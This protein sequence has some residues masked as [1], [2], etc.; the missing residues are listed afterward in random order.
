MLKQVKNN[1]PHEK[2]STNMYD[3]YTW[4]EKVINSCT[5]TEQ[6]SVSRKLVSAFNELYSNEIQL[7]SALYQQTHRLW[8]DLLDKEILAKVKSTHTKSNHTQVHNG[9]KSN[10]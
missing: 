7:S 6:V 4:I 10:S 5:T 3:V 9:K 2:R 1:I 8:S